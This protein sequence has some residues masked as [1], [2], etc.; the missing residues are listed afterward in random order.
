MKPFVFSF[1][2]CVLVLVSVNANAQ[3][4]GIRLGHTLTPSDHVSLKYEH[5][6]NGSV[7]FSLAGFFERSKR[8]ALNYSCYGADLLAEYSPLGAGDPLPLL[9]WRAGLGAT[10]QLVSEPWLYKGLS[11][12]QRMN[13]GLAGEAS[14]ECNLTD[15][16][17]LSLFG[18]Q[19]YL[20]RSSLG[21]TRFCYG[22]GLA[23]R[24]TSY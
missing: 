6:T 24:F 23:Y 17:R 5:W 11:P 14:F 15:V 3:S 4:I 16:F 21:S 7:N 22:L 12:S 13:Y 19:K 8:N 10:W 9:S 2:V 20:L 18:Q 1:V